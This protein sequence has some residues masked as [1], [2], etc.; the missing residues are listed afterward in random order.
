MKKEE[1]DKMS[2][3]L[4]DDELDAVSGGGSTTKGTHELVQFMGKCE[5]WNTCKGKNSNECRNGDGY[6]FYAASLSCYKEGRSR[7]ESLSRYIRH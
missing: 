6:A 4:S 3:E 2:M 7:E 1:K 5:Y